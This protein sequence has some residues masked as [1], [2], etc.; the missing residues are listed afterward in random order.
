MKILITTIL[1]LISTLTYSQTETFSIKMNPFPEQYSNEEW[2]GTEI[3]DTVECKLLITY[4]NECQFS[5]IN[6]GV[7]YRRFEC[8]SDRTAIYWDIEYFV[9]SFKKQIP[10]VIRVLG[11]NI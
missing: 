7:V 9:D 8:K 5:I 2:I 3:M 1:L 10:K 6:G 11:L 4:C